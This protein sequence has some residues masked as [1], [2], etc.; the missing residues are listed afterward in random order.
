MSPSQT[1]PA[2]PVRYSLAVCAVAAALI[3]RLLLNPYMGFTAPY[4]TF[5]AAVMLAAWFGGLGPGILASILSLLAADYFLIPPLHSLLMRNL[6]DII[7]GTGFSIVALFIT[8]LNEALRR[9][10]ARSEQ[11]FQQLAR[12]TARRTKA[13]QFLEQQVAERTAQLTA[14]NRELENFAYVAS[15][16]LKAPL[17]VIEN[18]T[19]WL[20]ED[21]A[22]HLD[23]ETRENMTLIRNRAK[24]MEKLLDDL[25]EYARLGDTTGPSY[26][27][28]VTGETL[29]ADVL[30]LL[31]TA[32]FTI[33]LS[34]NFAAIQVPRMP[35]QQILLNLIGNAIKHHHKKDGCIEVTVEDLG[36][37]YSFAVKDDGPGIPS[38]YHERIFQMFQTLRPRDQLEGSGMGLAL[39]RK[40]V[41]LFGGAIQVESSEGHGST[42]RFTFPKH[43]QAKAVAA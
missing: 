26:T 27:E 36:Q 4:M 24:R 31:A 23:A 14:A 17:R 5:F 29:L 41:E 8:L 9:S 15:H 12:E 1:A 34:S 25:L 16:D 38:C 3:L 2:T 20:E 39:V 13:E 33:Q 7:A 6:G 11:R 43:P 10:R 40:N 32:G 37:Q 19:I 21:L 42:F 30:A 22:A 28:T 35:L 18:A